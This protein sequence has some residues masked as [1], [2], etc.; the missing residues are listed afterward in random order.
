M[1]IAID[2]HCIGKNLAGNNTYTINLVNNLI[3]LYPGHKWI[4]YV[5]PEG[6]PLITGNNPNA[7]LIVLKSKS[8][9]GRYL[10][11]MPKSL[12]KEKPDVLHIQY[13]GPVFCG[14]P[15]VVTVHDIS[16]EIFPGYFTFAERLRLH[17][18]VPHFIRKAKS[19]ITVSDFSRKDIIR[20]YKIKENKIK[21]VYNGI[22]H[23]FFNNE[24]TAE[25]KNLLRE[26]GIKKPFLLSVGSLQPRK[27]IEGIL[28]ALKKI[29]KSIP[30]LRWIIT[31]P[32]GW[33]SAGIHKTFKESPELHSIINFTGYVQ[34]K[35]LRALYRNALAM[36]Y[37]PFYEGFG[38]PVLEAMAC[39]AP[40]ITSNVT[41]LPE[42]AGDAAILANPNDTN[43]ISEAVKKVW[44]SNGLRLEMSK[45]GVERARDFSW[46][47]AAEETF[48][49]LENAAADKT[50][51]NKI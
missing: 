37:V 14:C 44:L 13:H 41:S 29:Y 47:K 24:A 49:I 27:N 28:F 7:E 22:D 9:L 18:S 3:N 10:F 35:M 2:A 25:D 40:V 43:G 42:I 36:I 15:T 39:G 17:L 4:I 46:Q 34:P 51:K 12:K 20:K 50:Q 11:E 33:L 5:S 1:K 45:K 21:T 26:A 31:G 23:D 19:V 48:S 16:Y 38:L 30:G 32:E 6:E 8:P